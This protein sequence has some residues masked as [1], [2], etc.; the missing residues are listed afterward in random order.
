MGRFSN[1]Q[2]LEGW[3]RLATSPLKNRPVAAPILETNSRRYRAVKRLVIAVLEQERRPLWPA[4]IERPHQG[5]HG[6]TG[7]TIF[8][9]AFAVDWLTTEKRL[10]HP[11]AQR[12]PIVRPHVS[13]E[14]LRPLHRGAIGRR[15]TLE[16]DSEG[17]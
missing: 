6:R 4:E 3:D 14:R 12:L 17:C 8:D 9:Q 1:P 13:D 11:R 7:C 5:T 2:V 15:C 16:L 10:V